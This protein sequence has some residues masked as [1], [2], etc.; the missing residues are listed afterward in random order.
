VNLTNDDINVLSTDGLEDYYFCIVDGLCGLSL[1]SDPMQI[2]IAPDIIILKDLAIIYVC[3]GK[4][5]VLVI[6]AV[7]TDPSLEIAY[8]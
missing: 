7:S 2:K 8:S 1:Y 6:E 5:T 4:D 3:Q